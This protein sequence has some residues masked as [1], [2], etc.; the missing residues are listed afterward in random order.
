MFTP[1]KT[2]RIPHRV[3]IKDKD[4]FFCTGY[5]RKEGNDYA[6]TIITTVGNVLTNI[7]HDKGCM[8][9]IL[10]LKVCIQFLEDT[11]EERI[12]LCQ[13]YPPDKMNS[14]PTAL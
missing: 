12:A 3:T 14:K 11:L 5:Y 10:D 2:E 4:T 1:K 13:T 6:C 7:V 9:V 8:P